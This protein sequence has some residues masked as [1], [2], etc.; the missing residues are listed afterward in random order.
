MGTVSVLG[1]LKSFSQEADLTGRDVVLLCYEDVRDPS[2]HCHRTS[3]AEWV[4]QQTGE[5]IEELHDP[6][7]V[8]Y[9][10]Q[11]GKENVEPQPRES[12]KYEQMSLF[13]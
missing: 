5:I 11:E 3:L 6:S 2:Q 12:N 13:G 10:K 1:L 7:P 4:M 9:K 8:K